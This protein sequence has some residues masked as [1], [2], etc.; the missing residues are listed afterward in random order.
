MF[1]SK[2]AAQRRQGEGEDKAGAQMVIT[3][4]NAV[5]WPSK[6]VRAAKFLV[7]QAGAISRSRVRVMETPRQYVWRG[8]LLLPQAV[9]EQ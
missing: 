8:H 7:Q 9:I 3:F 6:C 2:E 4:V 1:A 5:L